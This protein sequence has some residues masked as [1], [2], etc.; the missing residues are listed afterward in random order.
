[1]LATLKSGGDGRYFAVK[2]IKKSTLVDEESLEHVLAENRVLQSTR[3]SGGSQS[4]PLLITHILPPAL[5]HPF[6]VRLYYSF[7]TTDR[8]YFVME[9]VSGGELFYHIGKEKRF[10]EDR[11]RFY[12][13]CILL[14]LHYLHQK[15]IVYRDLKLENLLLD[16]D[17]YMKITDFGRR[18]GVYLFVV[19]V[20]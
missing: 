11:V 8:L 19:C 15:D 2:I 1:M 18:W 13:A 4:N 14:A 17:G 9:Y 5:K 3:S 6:L 10:D 7:Q 20:C 12:A 16:R